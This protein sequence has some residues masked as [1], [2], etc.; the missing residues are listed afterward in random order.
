MDV[1]QQNPPVASCY[2]PIGTRHCALAP[3]G[4]VLIARNPVPYGA[5][6]VD[7]YQKGGQSVGDKHFLFVSKGLARDLQIPTAPFGN[8]WPDGDASWRPSRLTSIYDGFDIHT[9]FSTTGIDRNTGIDPNVVHVQVSVEPT[10]TRSIPSL[11]D[12]V[13]LHRHAY[14]IADWVMGL[15]TRDSS[16][17]E[18]EQWRG[19]V[20]ATKVVPLP[21]S[22]K[23]FW[24]LYTRG[25]VA[26]V[27]SDAAS[28]ILAACD[29][30]DLGPMENEPAT[31]ALDFYWD[32][33]TGETSVGRG[34]GTHS[35]IGSGVESAISAHAAAGNKVVDGD[36]I[37]GIAAV[38]YSGV[39][40]LSFDLATSG[41]L[42]FPPYNMGYKVSCGGKRIILASKEGVDGRDL[43]ELTKLASEVFPASYAQ[44]EEPTEM[45]RVYLDQLFAAT[46][47]TAL[48][49]SVNHN[50]EA[51]SATGTPTMP[52]TEASPWE[53]RFRDTVSSCM[54]IFEAAVRAAAN[55]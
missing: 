45:V 54:R 31:M 21:L 22:V 34:M 12:V 10:G 49:T 3:G 20:A 48:A 14:S 44:T 47:E 40:V 27:R 4:G 23:E 36:N 52:A 55:G 33:A 2:V 43:S 16:K 42:V 46:A 1:L 18:G 9:E 32:A 38:K 35:I 50:T 5:Y 24:H 13:F 41:A 11:G 29:A 7:M 17:P 25:A 28:K 15:V 39:S 30:V 8:T 26:N 19:W 51:N 53:P 6:T 37:F